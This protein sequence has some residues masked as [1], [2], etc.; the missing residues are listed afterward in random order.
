MNMQA[1]HDLA[2]EAVAKKSEIEANEH[3]EAA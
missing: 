2:L 1:S 3:L